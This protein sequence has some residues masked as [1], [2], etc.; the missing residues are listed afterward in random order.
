[1]SPE[2]NDVAIIV[3]SLVVD[4]QIWLYRKLVHYQ[5]LPVNEQ[6][7]NVSPDYILLPFNFINY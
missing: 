6:N 3:A 2:H 7:L 4:Q 1:M 5:L